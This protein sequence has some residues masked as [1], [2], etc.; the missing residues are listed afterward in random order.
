MLFRSPDIS[1]V[2]V[3]TEE[4]KAE[5]AKGKA[6]EGKGVETKTTDEKKG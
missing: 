3:E 1:A 4:K 6:E 2:K 5:R